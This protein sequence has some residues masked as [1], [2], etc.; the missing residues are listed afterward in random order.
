MPKVRRNRTRLHTQAAATPH[1][2]ER[3]FAAQ[4]NQVQKLADASESDGPGALNS[5]K[6]DKRK[7]RHDN[8]LSKLHT[9]HQEMRKSKKKDTSLNMTMFNEALPKVEANKK[10]QEQK[11]TSQE[12]LGKKRVA[13]KKG[14]KNTA[15]Q[16]IVR[17]Q[18]I[19]KHPDFQQNPLQTIQQHVANTVETRTTNE[20]Q[21]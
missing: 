1:I 3:A 9:A 7:Q 11:P 19:L 18:N 16:E 15:L 21:S 20:E 5:S 13:T 12:K 14:R 4:D 2:S 10:G 17:F 6:K 8:W